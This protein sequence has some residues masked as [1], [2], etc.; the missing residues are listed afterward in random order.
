[1]DNGRNDVCGDLLEYAVGGLSAER[2]A[3]FIDHLD[4]CPA[5]RA[6]LPLIR[7]AWDLLPYT[8]EPLDP[9]PG[10]KKAVLQSAREHELRASGATSR[11]RRPRWQLAL[12]A[13]MILVVLIGTILNYRMWEDRRETAAALPDAPATITK[14]VPLQAEDAGGGSY[15]IA[16]IVEQGASAQLVVYVFGAKATVGEQAYQVWLIKDGARTSGGTFRVGEDG[17]GVL[18]API[19]GGSPAFDAVGITLEPDAGGMSPRGSRVFSG[20]ER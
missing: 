14:L 4:G 1:M 2:R 20:S 17:I 9:P 13:A 3:A 7:E 16:C 8:D 11:R 18:A 6:E 12:S 15:G 10:L 19:S 5:C